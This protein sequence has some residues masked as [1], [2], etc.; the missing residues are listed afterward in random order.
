[1]A[2][3]AWKARITGKKMVQEALAETDGPTDEPAVATDV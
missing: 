2:F 3:K 1:V